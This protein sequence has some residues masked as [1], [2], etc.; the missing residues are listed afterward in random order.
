MRTYLKFSYVLIFIIILFLP[1]VSTTLGFNLDASLNEKRAKAAKPVF[2]GDG[3]KYIKKYYK[4]F[5][6]NFT[7][8]DVCIGLYNNFKF[9]ILGEST[10]PDRV[11]IGKDNYLFYSK[12]KD[13]KT[14]ED[15]QGLISVSEQQINEINDELKKL[16]QWLSANGIDFFL[17]IA[18]DKHTIYPEKMPDYISR[19]SSS[20]TDRIIPYLVQHNIYIIDLRGPLK[21]AK[22]MNDELYYKTDTHWNSLGAYIGYCE[23]IKSLSVNYSDVRAIKINLK[24]IKFTAY[25]NAGDLYDMLGIKDYKFYRDAVLHFRKN[26]KTIEST[27]KLIV[28]EGPVK[29]PRAVIYRDSFCGAL[30]P[31]LSNNF[32]YVSY[33]SSHK[34][35]TIDRDYILKI[36]PDILFIEIVERHL[37]YLSIKMI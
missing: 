21:K 25:A 34:I 24:N 29:S 30:Q 11:L 15:Y 5:I 16:N 35:Y 20:A 26:Y 18:P 23:I 37:K 19:G 36:K 28:T 33:I 14:I 12:S 1:F 9:Y 2:N 7:G 4:F 32:S 8:R 31:M 10:V 27:D 17:I 13:E 3:V 6:D 22:S